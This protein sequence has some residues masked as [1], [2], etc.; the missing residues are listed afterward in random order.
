MPNNI[1]FSNF[2]AVLS[3]KAD[4]AVALIL[5]KMVNF[6]LDQPILIQM[7]KILLSGAAL[8]LSFSVFA[9]KRTFMPVNS[10]MPKLAKC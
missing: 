8:L 4:D 3:P 5:C 2:I 6:L 7:R 10:S 9:K 1:G